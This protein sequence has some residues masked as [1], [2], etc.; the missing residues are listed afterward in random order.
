MRVTYKIE[1]DLPNDMEVREVISLFRLLRFQ[2]LDRIPKNRVRFKVSSG[3]KQLVRCTQTHE[4]R[5]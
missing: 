2:V 4:A 1:L 5:A 3:L